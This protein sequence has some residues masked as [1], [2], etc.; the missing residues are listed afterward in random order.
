MGTKELI[1]TTKAA[2]LIGVSANTLRRWSEAG[3]GPPRYRLGPRL[4]VYKVEEVRHFL[5]ELR[6]A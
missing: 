1:D 6:P 5:A 2:D 3:V 4:L